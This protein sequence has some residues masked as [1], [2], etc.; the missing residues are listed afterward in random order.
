MS[1]LL[2]YYMSVLLS[3]RKVHILEDQ[4]T[5]PCPWTIKSWKIVKNFTFCY[6]WSLEVHEVMVKNGLLT[7]IRYYLLNTDTYQWVILHCNPVLLSS[8]KVL[9]LEVQFTSPCPCPQT[10]SPCLCPRASSP[11]QHQ[12]HYYM[13][14]NCIRQVQW[15]WP[16]HQWPV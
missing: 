6:V 12:H 15:P 10:T 16:S 5:S 7:D 3:L 13:Y 4:F 8:R 11:W 9:V 14:K 1:P 2:H